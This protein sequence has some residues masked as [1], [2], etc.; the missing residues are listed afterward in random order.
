MRNR[1]K[2]LI[3]SKKHGYW[4]EETKTCEDHWTIDCLHINRYVT[5]DGIPR[6]VI[7]C[8]GCGRYFVEQDIV[9]EGGIFFVQAWCRNYC[10]DVVTQ[11]R[12]LVK[13]EGITMSE[14]VMKLT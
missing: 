8:S 14:A 5:I 12:E 1:N 13:K 11:A 6:P 2:V 4:I 10:N 9:I 7:L 3:K